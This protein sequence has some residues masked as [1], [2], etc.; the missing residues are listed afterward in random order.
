MN[1]SEWLL[2]RSCGTL[3][4]TNTRLEILVMQDVDV[5]NEGSG[6]EDV[7]RPSDGDTKAHVG[8]FSETGTKAEFGS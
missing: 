3:R 6:N 7:A 4:L 5:L 1:K 8:D 2:C